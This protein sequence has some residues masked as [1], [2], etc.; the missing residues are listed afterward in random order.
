MNEEQAA[1]EEVQ[2]L[3][4]ERR[5]QEIPGQERMFDRLKT[6]EGEAKQAFE[7]PEQKFNQLANPIMRY[8][9][10]AH[11]PEKLQE[12]SAPF[13]R[14]AAFIEAHLPNGPE[15]STALRKLLEAKDAAVRSALD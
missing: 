3:P 5:F 14:L 12:V 8:F 15:K 9:D 11:L 1:Q 7:Q 2:D 4:E 10:Y 13:G 6:A